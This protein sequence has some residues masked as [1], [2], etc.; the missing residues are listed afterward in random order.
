MIDNNPTASMARAYREMHPLQFLREMYF[1]AVEAGA[2]VARIR[3]VNNKLAFCDDGC[4]MNP[5]DLLRLINGRNS[6]SKCTDGRHANFGI[7]LKDSALTPNPYGLVV[8]SKTKEK[9]KGGMIW[10]HQQEGIS[11]AKLLISEEMRRDF[12]NTA[13]DGDEFISNYLN[14][15]YS[16][17][18]EW[19]QSEFGHDSFTIDGI[20]WMSMFSKCSANTIIML[21][22]NYPSAVTLS[23]SE[24]VPFTNFLCSRIFSDPIKLMLPTWESDNEKFWRRLITFDGA[25]RVSDLFEQDFKD[26]KIRTYIRKDAVNHKGGVGTSRNGLLGTRQFCFGVLYNNEIFN[27][28]YDSSVNG[29]KRAATSAKHWGLYYP[30]VYKRVIILVEPPKFD[31]DTGIGCFPNST[32]KDLEWSDPRDNLDAVSVEV[33]LE[34]I[35]AWYVENMPT[36]LR[37]LINAEVEKT[38]SNIERSNKI[39]Q[40]RKFFQAP[41]VERTPTSSSEGD[42]FSIGTEAGAGTETAQETSLLD[43]YFKR[44]SKKLNPGLSQPNED[45]DEDENEDK[46]DNDKKDNDDKAKDKEGREGDNSPAERMKKLSS[47]QDASVVFVKKGDPTW[48][49]YEALARS[50]SNELWPFCYTGRRRADNVNVIYVNT[51]SDIICALVRSALD[52]VDRRGPAKLNMSELECLEHLVK[53]FIRDYMPVSL[54]H[55][56]S[57]KSKIKLGLSLTDPVVLYAMFHGTWQIQS[58][59]KD[60]YDEYRRALNSLTKA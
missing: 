49:A 23:D 16:I 21:M 43:E 35:K 30:D 18:F 33:P 7:G 12:C 2:T 56:N 27:Y 24:N 32:R 5:E 20:N 59:L 4:G 41:K 57:D 34:E 48:T 1:N 28:Q 52:W 44:R 6:S 14:E 58:N 60:Y 8:L 36:E 29:N 38:L 26:F 3:K 45:E 9:P 37:S 55:L 51:E 47:N 25:N 54:A 10:L 13:E 15:L 11:G 50:D 31:E 19:I 17:D 53:P 22:G 42:L 46:E 39:A 40:Y